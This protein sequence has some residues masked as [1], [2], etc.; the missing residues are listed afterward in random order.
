[1]ILVPFL[2]LQASFLI[3]LLIVCLVGVFFGIP[4]RGRMSYGKFAIAG[5]I[6]FTII[7]VSTYAVFS[8]LSFGVYN[9]PPP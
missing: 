4:A 6:L 5:P 3:A 7:L 2:A 1:V 9:P 8:A